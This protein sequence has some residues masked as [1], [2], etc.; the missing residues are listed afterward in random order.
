MLAFRRRLLVL[1]LCVSINLFELA[2]YTKGLE[3]YVADQSQL[4]L[5]F[6]YVCHVRWLL[7]CGV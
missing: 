5:A 7:A 4:L 2:I 6:G 3:N 1:L